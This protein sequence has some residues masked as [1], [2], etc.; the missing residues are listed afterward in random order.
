MLQIWL[1]FAENLINGMVDL[2]AEH[3]QMN[4]GL[5]LLKDKKTILKTTFVDLVE[6][7]LSEYQRGHEASTSIL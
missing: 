3:D 2:H 1:A 4:S 5:A 7:I 6:L